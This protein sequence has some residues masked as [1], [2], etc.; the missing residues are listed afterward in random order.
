MKRYLVFIFTL[1]YFTAA[2]GT[3]LEFHHCM[4]KL[5]EWG[6]AESSE[7][8]DCSNCKMSAEASKDCCKKDQHIVKIEQAQKAQFNCEFKQIPTLVTQPFSNCTRIDIARAI[9]DT[10]NFL[11]V[12]PLMEKTPVCILLSTFRI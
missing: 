4:G 5:V 8:E 2:S 11:H 10:N 7:S 12:P 3:S 9:T 6:M 1:F